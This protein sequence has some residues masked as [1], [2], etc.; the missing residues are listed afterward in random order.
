MLRKVKDVGRLGRWIL[1]LAP[2]KFKV[3]HTRDRD[4]MVAD[5]LSQMF[6]DVSENNTEVSCALLL[7]SFPLVYSSLAEHQAKDDF[8]ADREGNV[9]AELPGPENFQLHKILLLLP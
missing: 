1:R 8:C 2:F 7:D 4:N 3:Q 6:G 5:T 9:Q